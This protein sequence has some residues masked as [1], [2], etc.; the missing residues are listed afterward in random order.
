MCLYFRKADPLHT[1]YSCHFGIWFLIDTFISLAQSRIMCNHWSPPPAV[2]CVGVRGSQT[3]ERFNTQRNLRLA[4]LPSDVYLISCVSIISCPHVIS[5]RPGIVSVLMWFQYVISVDIS[6][7]CVRGGLTFMPGFASS[8]SAPS[9]LSAFPIMKVRLIWRLTWS[10][11]N[12]KKHYRS[13]MGLCFRKEPSTSCIKS[14]FT[15]W[16]LKLLCGSLEVSIGL[17]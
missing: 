9:R 15:V 3:G 13:L 10:H 8:V 1:L 4:S 7:V 16:S 17:F 14:H 2:G 5:N 11:K 6:S 12:A